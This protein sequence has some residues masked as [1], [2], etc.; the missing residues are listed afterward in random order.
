MFKHCI[1]S[2]YKDFHDKD[3]IHNIALIV[4]VYVIPKIQGHLSNE[5]RLTE[6]SLKWIIEK[7]ISFDNSIKTEEFELEKEVILETFEMSIHSCLN[8]N[9]LDK[10]LKSLASWLSKDGEKRYH[11]EWVWDGAYFWIVQVDKEE[12]VEVGTKPG[13]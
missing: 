4:Q 2:I 12:S 9:S 5:R 10:S 7:E 3:E 8:T 6:E 11:V 1:K 13:F